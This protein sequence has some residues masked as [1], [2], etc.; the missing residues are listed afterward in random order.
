MSGP[1]KPTRTE[2]MRVAIAN[3]KKAK[4]AAAATPAAPKAT[5]VPAATDKGPKK[6]RSFNHRTSKA[7]DA[8]AKARG[9]L[10][11]GANFHSAWD[12]TSHQG[13]LVVPLVPE[14]DGRDCKV[15]VHSTDG[16]FRLMEELDI[17]FW[18][19]FVKEATVEEKAKL[20]FVTDPPPPQP[21]TGVP[22]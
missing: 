4:V 9:R 21:W 12:G 8:R 13:S 20:V 10:P 1:K 16:L 6:E 5:V 14:L 15:F 19:W 3:G 18:A 17:M 7:R 11:V 22:T 2:Q